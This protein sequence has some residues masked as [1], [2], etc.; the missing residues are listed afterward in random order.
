ML[1]GSWENP[2]LTCGFKGGFTAFREGGRC[3][4]AKHSRALRTDQEVLLLSE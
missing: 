4:R 1:R 3:G 2:G